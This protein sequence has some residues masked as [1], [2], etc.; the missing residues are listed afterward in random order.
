MLILVGHSHMFWS[1]LT[2]SWSRMALNGGKMSFQCVLSSFSKVGQVCSHGG[3][4]L[5]GGG[6]TEGLYAQ[7]WYADTSTI[8]LLAK[9]NHIQRGEKIDSTS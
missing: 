7:T 3:S 6:R 8:I 4:A 5:K 9:V 1:W 2:A